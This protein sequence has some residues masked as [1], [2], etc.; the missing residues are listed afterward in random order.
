MND[1]RIRGLNLKYKHRD[2]PTDV[3]AFDISETKSAADLFADIIVSCDTAVRNARIFK[4]SP[5]YEVYLYVVHGLL[6]LI[7]YDDKNA[8]QRKVMDEKCVRIL[9]ELKVNLRR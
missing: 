9:N 3:L 2:L 4:T 7:G 1:K 6:H 5:R 8:K